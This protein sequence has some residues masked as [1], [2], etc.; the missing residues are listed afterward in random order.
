MKK[1][2]LLFFI[3]LSLIATAQNRR[4]SEGKRTGKWVYTGKDRPH[5]GYAKD[6]KVEEGSYQNGRKEGLWIKYHKDGKTPKLKG[7]YTNNRPDG[8]YT[9]FYENGQVSEQGY[10]GNN[11]YKG[12]LTRYHE[13]GQVAYKAT[14]NNEGQESGKVQYYHENGKLALEYTV[15]SGTVQGKV[16]RYN[17]Q[18]Q[19]VNSLE[20]SP[21]G[22]VSKFQQVQVKPSQTQPIAVPNAE[23]YPPRLAN[24]RTKGLKFSPNGYNKVYNDN[25]EIWMDGDFKNGQLWDGKVYDYDTDGILKKVRI[26]KFGKYHSDG[27]L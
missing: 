5:S 7:N 6:A 13:N 9:R 16:L 14:Y 11:G 3:F 24:P 26:F 12:P 18:G 4:N 8:N 10:F 20:V 23:I 22:T 25:D 17:T 21:D 2:L 19:L 1:Q 27:Q 15:K